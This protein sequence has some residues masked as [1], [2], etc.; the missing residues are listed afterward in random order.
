MTFKL[1]FF[2]DEQTFQERKKCET[3]YQDGGRVGTK[4]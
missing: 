4:V 1:R 2:K 3:T